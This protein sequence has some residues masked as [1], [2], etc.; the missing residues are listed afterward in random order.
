MCPEEVF[1]KFCKKSALDCQSERTR[2]QEYRE[3]AESHRAV[4][5][6]KKSDSKLP[7]TRRRGLGALRL[8]RR[9]RNLIKT[10]VFEARYTTQP[11]S[12]PYDKLSAQLLRE[13]ADLE[14]ERKRL[15]DSFRNDNGVTIDPIGHDDGF[16][17]RVTA[18]EIEEIERELGRC[19][20]VLNPRS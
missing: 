16:P 17:P 1:D 11:M 7:K 14:A 3:R 12:N 10:D 6:R 13:Y 4:N 8:A 18:D 20:V 15:M 9:R 19:F 2:R 5:R